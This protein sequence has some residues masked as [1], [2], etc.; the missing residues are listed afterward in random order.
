MANKT[1]LTLDNIRTWAETYAADNGL[2]LQVAYSDLL[3]SFHRYSMKEMPSSSVASIL[4]IILACGYVGFQHM[5]IEALENRCFNEFINEETRGI[6]FDCLE[7]LLS[8]I[9]WGVGWK[10]INDQVKQ[11]TIGHI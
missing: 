4:A 9:E 6:D 2:S 3:S 11:E 5:S 8:A 10:K 7:D 1:P